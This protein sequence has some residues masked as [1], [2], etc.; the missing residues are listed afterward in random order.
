M[1]HTPAFTVG[2][3]GHMALDPNDVDTASDTIRAI[4]DW[5]MQSDTTGG[6]NGLECLGAPLGLSATSIVLLSSLAPGVDQIAANIACQRGICVQAPLPFPHSM[7]REA[8]TFRRGNEFDAQRQADYDAIIEKVGVS[9]V[10]FVKR[11]AD[12]ELDPTALSELL[13]KDLHDRVGRNYRY[14]AAGEFIATNCDLLIAVCDRVAASDPLEVDH[15]LPIDAQ[16]GAAF[17]VDACLYGATPG[18]LPMKSSLTWSDNGPVV[19]VFIRNMKKELPENAPPKGHVAVWHPIDSRPVAC[20]DAQWHNQQMS[21]LR[22]LAGRV[23]DMNQRLSLLTHVDAEKECSGLLTVRP[24]ALYRPRTLLQ[25]LWYSQPRPPA[26]DR[27]HAPEK[28]KA[29]AVLRRKAAAINRDADARIKILIKWFLLIAAAIVLL[30][31]VCEYWIPLSIEQQNLT[32]SIGAVRAGLF[33]LAVGLSGL[34]WVILFRVRKGRYD[35]RQNDF[36]AIAEALRVQFFWAASGTGESVEQRYLQRQKNELSWI[37]GVVSSASIPV[38]A[39]REEFEALS[40]TER[41]DRLRRIH[42]GWIGEQWTYFQRVTFELGQRKHWLHFFAN[43]FLVAGVLMILV[44]IAA[45]LLS[46]E[47]LVER[48]A[49]A[50]GPFALPQVLA[51]LLLCFLLNELIALKAWK[52][53]AVG[54]GDEASQQQSDSQKSEGFWQTLLLCSEKTT[55]SPWTVFALGCLMGVAS[56]CTIFGNAWDPVWFPNAAKLS[57]ILKNVYLASAG[58]LHSW[59]AFHF[60]THNVRRYSTMLGLYR[61]ANLR[62]SRFLTTLEEQV[63]QKAPQPEL[64][65][66]IRAIQSLLVEL[67]VESLNE[68]SEWLQMHRTTPIAPLMPVG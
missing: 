20:T 67:G 17:V 63:R 65:Q 45:H 39:D 44:G 62:M 10:F 32:D 66:T 60:L 34:S 31:Q 11:P 9:N 56:V 38:T 48:L 30:L 37:R 50:W 57:T 35:E 47:H 36:R 3:S 27:Y 64:Q 2:V 46:W 22:E 4:L 58:L 21:S 14:R 16:P 68:N 40:N 33:F 7:Y 59:A 43:T 55:Q 23:E 5:L 29:L 49:H 54:A 51:G 41:L 19:R 24:P 26:P 52:Q 1:Q 13:S 18:V 25:R 8:S 53:P 61:G 12:L 28:L 15:G 6:I 42:D